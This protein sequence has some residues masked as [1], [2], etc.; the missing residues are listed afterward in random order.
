MQF[1]AETAG[2]AKVTARPLHEE[3]V[4]AA[5]HFVGLVLSLAG[6][7]ALMMAVRYGEVGQAIA[8]GVYATTLILTYGISSLSHVV[9][10]SRPKHLLSIWDQGVIYF[11]IVGTYTPFVF[12][13]AP[14]YLAWPVLSV[15]WLAAAVGFGSKVILQYRVRESFSAL[16]YVLLGWVPGIMLLHIVPGACLTWIV[17]GGVSYTF[18]VLFLTFDDKYRFFHALWHVLVILGSG[19]HFYAVLTFAA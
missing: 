11:L 7:A 4:N 6:T 1:I 17:L 10:R 19:C 16:S 15:I 8:C 2:G 5:T 9:Q 12:A 13:F 18:G 3:V 14:E